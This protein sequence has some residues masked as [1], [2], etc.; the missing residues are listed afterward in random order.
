MSTTKM[1]TKV[2]ANIK[3]VSP[4]RI[5]NS[6]EVKQ[7]VKKLT[8]VLDKNAAPK[9]S[10][11]KKSSKKRSSKKRSSK[12]TKSQKK[13]RST[14]RKLSP[15]KFSQC[16]KGSLVEAIKELRKYDALPREKV[17]RSIQYQR[18]KFRG[19]NKK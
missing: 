3:N 13:P 9:K 7:A 6:P 15:R 11:K 4:S 14:Y 2:L 5:R 8:V 1:T 12:R 19:S 18:R 17:C 10:S 16:K